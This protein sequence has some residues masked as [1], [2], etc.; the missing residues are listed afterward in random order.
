LVDAVS[1]G[2]EDLVVAVTADHSTPS[3]SKLIHSG[4]P[5]PLTLVGRHVRR[6]KVTSFDEVSVAKGCLGFLRGRELMLMLLNYADRSALVGHCLDGRIRPYVPRRYPPF[7][8]VV[9]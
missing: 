9:D 2:R 5:V 8:P 3:V 1:N 4:E 6:D 7:E